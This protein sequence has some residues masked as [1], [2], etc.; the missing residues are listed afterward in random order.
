MKPTLL[1]LLLPH[2]KLDKVSK[3]QTLL[4]KSMNYLWLFHSIVAGNLQK[5]LSVYM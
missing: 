4:L 5:S 3:N 1:H 2:I